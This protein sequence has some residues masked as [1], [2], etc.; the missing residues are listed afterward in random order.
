MEPFVKDFKPKC[1]AVCC[2]IE[3]V[4]TTFKKTFDEVEVPNPQRSEDQK[5]VLLKKEMKSQQL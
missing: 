4:T 2:S 3:E 1:V 5:G